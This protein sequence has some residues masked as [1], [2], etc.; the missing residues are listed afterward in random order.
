VYVFACASAQ[1]FK[2]AGV[3][4]SKPGVRDLALLSLQVHTAFAEQ[5]A[6][7]GLVVMMTFAES[8]GYTRSNSMTN[9]MIL[10]WSNEIIAAIEAG[11]MADIVRLFRVFYV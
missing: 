5:A 10:N 8:F 3:P 2:D 4:H 1:S 7:T 9:A 11:Q 6:L